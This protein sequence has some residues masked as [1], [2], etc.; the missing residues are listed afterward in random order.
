MSKESFFSGETLESAALVF[1]G[2]AI[3]GLSVRAYMKSMLR[4]RGFRVFA[5]SSKEA[6][7]SL[8]KVT[9]QN[10]LPPR[11]RIEEEGGHVR[12]ALLEDNMTV[13]NVTDPEASQE[14]GDPSAALMMKAKDPKAAASLAAETLMA[15]GFTAEIVGHTTITDEV[16]GK[17][18][19]LHTDALKPGASLGFREHVKDMGPMPPRWHKGEQPQ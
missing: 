14:I 9:S 4:D 19:F 17:M 7:D 13:I 16:Q 3:G 5:A 1:G 6:Q 18:V 12:R 2:G 11:R 10:G 15:D 8:L